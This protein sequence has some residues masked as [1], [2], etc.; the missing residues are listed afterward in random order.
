MNV[1]K[2]AE[3]L[4]DVELDFEDGHDGLHLVE[5]ARGTIDGLGDEFKYEV[6]VDFVFLRLEELAMCGCG[7]A[8]LRACEHAGQGRGKRGRKTYTLAI[9]VE[10]GLEFYNVGV[11]DYAHDLEF[12]VLEKE[13]TWVRNA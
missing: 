12:A 10:E 5:V 1:R 4:V 13:S 11:P 8:A 7:Q 3:E 2:R 6:E 9:V